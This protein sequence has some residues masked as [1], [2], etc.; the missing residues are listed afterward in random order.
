[1]NSKY[2][3]YVGS[4]TRGEG[5]GIYM[6]DVDGTYGGFAL[7]GCL[8]INNPSYLT[9][10]HDGNF[11]Y[12]NCDEGVASFKILEDGNLELINKMQVNGLRPCYLSTDKKNRYLVTAGYHDGKLTVLRL[13]KDGSIGPV[14][15]NV[16]MKSIG[17][18]VGRNYRCHVNCALFSPDEKY[19]LAVDLGADQVKIYSFNHVTGK[20]K[21]KDILRCELESGP[22]HMVFSKNGKFAYLTHENK[23]YVTVYAY[24]EK[25][26]AFKKL[27]TIS[28]LP[29]KCSVY[30]SAVTLKLS[31][32]EMMKNICL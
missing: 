11:L 16:F 28:T 1:M 27:Q 23:N 9:I 10:S 18:V 31:D 7:R 29:E 8:E 2:V 20:I 6:Y 13:N 5:K 15:D 24:D 25:N 17:S 22:K 3:A 4:Y 32:D 19:I 30:N 12:S 14:T 21:L 26:V